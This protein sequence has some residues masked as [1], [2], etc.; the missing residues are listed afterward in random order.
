MHVRSP[1]LL[2]RFRDFRFLI[3]E[4]LFLLIVATGFTTLAGGRQAYYN[5]YGLPVF[6]PYAILIGL[7]YFLRILF[8]RKRASAARSLVENENAGEAPRGVDHPRKA[9]D[10]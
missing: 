7:A 6:A 4:L 9:L 1:T 10:E 2:G 8:L 3:L 5:N